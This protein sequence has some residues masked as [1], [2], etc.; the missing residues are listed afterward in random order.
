MIENELQAALGKLISNVMVIGDKRKFLTCILTLSVKPNPEAPPQTYPLSNRLSGDALEIVK[1]LG[2]KAETVEDA[3]KDPL[4]NNYIKQKIG[5]ANK[6]AISNA[7]CVQKY[8][9]APKD[10]TIEGDELTP[11]LKLKRKIVLEKYKNE[12]EEMYIDTN[13]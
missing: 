2:S 5:E 13:N 11:T 3:Q 4:I 7:H 8:I 1:S 10:F 9:I 6:N 12:I